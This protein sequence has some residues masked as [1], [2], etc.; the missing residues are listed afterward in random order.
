MTKEEYIF[1][2]AKDLKTL[3]KKRDKINENLNGN[4]TYNKIQ[5]L[6]ADLGWVCMQ[7]GQAEERLGFALGYL[8][9]DDIRDEWHPSGWH[10]YKGLKGELSKLKFD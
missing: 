2:A 8:S 9:I 4:N 3:S 5:K 1:L 10:T 6:H 7:I